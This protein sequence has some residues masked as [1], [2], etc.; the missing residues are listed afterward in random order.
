MPKFL[1]KTRPDANLYVLWSTV[2]DSL[3]WVG[4]REQALKD[5]WVNGDREITGRCHCCGQKWEGLAAKRVRLADQYGSSSVNDE[6][7]EVWHGW[8][9]DGLILANHGADPGRPAFLW[10]PR[11]RLHDF[12]ELYRSD[13]LGKALCLCDDLEDDDE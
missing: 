7:G 12:A 3:I 10:L 8:D 4:T 2:T 5:C 9:D 1:M 6:T 13:Q 11:N